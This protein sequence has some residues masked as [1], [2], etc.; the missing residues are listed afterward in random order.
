MEIK[1]CVFDIAGTTVEDHNHVGQCLVEALAEVGL[2]PTIRQLNAIMGM[3]KP[4]A[5]RMLLERAGV[6]AEVQDIYDDFEAR[7]IRFYAEQPVRPIKGAPEAIGLLRDGGVK[8]F[9]DTGFASAV[10]RQVVARMG[11]E[12]L[13]DGKV[14]SDEVENGRPHA[15][16]VYLAMERAGVSDPKFVLKACDTPSDIGEGRAAGCGV[17]VGVLSGCHTRAELESHRPDY[18]LESVALVPGLIGL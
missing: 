18:V 8:V 11:W 15:D 3:P 16:L 14:S 1:L 13:L 12:A 6:E 7:M 2:R 10:T 4:V 17:V 5:I 9:L